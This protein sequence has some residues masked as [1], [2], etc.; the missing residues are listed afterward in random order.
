MDDMEESRAIREQQVLR[1]SEPGR[2]NDEEYRHRLDEQRGLRRER[3]DTSYDHR[4]RGPRGYQ[5]SDER[6]SDDIHD[7]LTADRHLDAREI[8]I[9]ITDAEVTLTGMVDSRAARR[10]AEDIAENVSGVRYVLNNIRVRQPGTS[11]ATG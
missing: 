4:G 1:S 10:R 11:G 9:S 7:R 2:S 3:P 8:Q 6:I 5:R